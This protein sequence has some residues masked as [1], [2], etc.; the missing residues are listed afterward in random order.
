VPVAMA[1]RLEPAGSPADA[2]APADDGTTFGFALGDYDPAHPLVLDPA[3]LLYCGYLG[4]SG[5]DSGNDIAVDAAG[6]AYVTGQ[7][8]SSETSFPA[9]VGPDVT[10]NGSDDAFVAKVN[11][12]GTA[13]VYCGYLGGSGIDYGNG[14]AVDAAGNAYVAGYTASTEQTFPVVVGPDLT[15]NGG[16][17]DAFVARVNV[18]GTALDYCGYIGG[19]GN[20]RGF[21]I[22]ASAGGNAY[23]IGVADSTQATFPVAVGPDV[24]HNGFNDAFVAKVNTQGTALDYCGYVGGSSGEQGVAIAVDPAGCT[25]AT[26]HTQSTQ[27]FPVAVGP[28]LTHNGGQYDAWVA[29]VNAAGTALDYCGYLGGNG[30]D[31]GRSI[32]VDAAGNPY[33]TGH[34]QSNEQTFPVTVGPDLTHNGGQDVFVTKVDSPT[35]ALVYC[36]YLGGAAGE[37]GTSIAVDAAGN[38][39]VTGNTASDEQTFPATGGPDLTFNGGTNDAFVAKVDP[40]GMALVYCGYLGG[41]GAD[42]GKGI[43][44]D[45][46]GNAYVAGSTQSTELT[47]PVAAGPDLTH[48][49]GDDAFAAKVTSTSLIGVGA[50]TPGGQVNLALS[51]PGEAGL[52]YQLASSFGSG[53]I[54]IDTRRIELSPDSLLVFSISG[55]APSIFRNYAGVL[56]AQGQASAALH[57][58]NIPGL[59]TIRIYTA[60]VTLKASAPSG[61]ASISNPFLFT[62]Q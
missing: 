4:G 36:G 3:V 42:L 5:T 34:T 14:V 28:D 51:A 1:Y 18:Q 61:V 21:G 10:H 26:G 16:T 39:Y 15:Y 30:D 49:G 23:V 29:K 45:A 22:A 58:P 41:D 57:I 7:T 24:T 9:A 46:A 50:P 40:L 44:V 25:Y 2:A 32:A 13:L 56:D 52:P 31:R 55:A 53:P 54:P 38:A 8:Q 33:V 11:A 20:D 6:N 12:A 48:N 19:S 37:S 60:F 17:Y 47:F 62:I 59:R 35:A 27:G 43:A